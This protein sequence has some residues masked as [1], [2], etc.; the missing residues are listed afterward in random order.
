MSFFQLRILLDI[1]L[2]PMRIQT[3]NSRTRA[4]ASVVAV[5]SV[6]CATCAR[7]TEFDAQTA[8]ENLARKYTELSDLMARYIAQA[9][10]ERGVR[11]R[12]AL[13]MA[14]VLA[15][16]V[17]GVPVDN[18]HPDCCL[19]GQSFPNGTKGWFCTGV[20]IHPRIV[21]TAGHCHEPPDLRAN[22]VALS[23][24]D[25]NR[26][27]DAEILSVRRSVVHPNY[28]QTRQLS[29]LTVL[30]LRRDA[31]T[32][33][34]PV[35]TAAEINEASETLLV[36]FGRDD[37]QSTRGF[38]RKRKVEVDITSIRRAASDDLDEAEGRLGF[39]SDLEFVAGGEGFDSC[40]GDS[41]GPAYIK[42]G[43][44]KKLAG[45]TSRGTDSANRP[46]GDGGIYTRVDKHMDFV[47]DVAR[48]AGI[49][50]N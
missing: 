11:N 1:L 26:L 27:G 45:L 23:A 17:G 32:A 22:A 39:E 35:A 46:C 33:P 36:G 42:V 43:D 18:E 14:R 10:L 40:N 25:Q 20:L 4:R 41:G 3:M 38:G 31:R 21:L 12:N 44:T 9:P 8:Y 34:V 7:S 30:V 2:L 48:H 29:D 5:P 37:V 49:D 13:E 24:D 16:I 50:L 28:Q 15:R 19:V 47:A 6:P